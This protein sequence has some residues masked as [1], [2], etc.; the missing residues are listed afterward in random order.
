MIFCFRNNFDKVVLF[1]Y[2]APDLAI[3][4]FKIYVAYYFSVMVVCRTDNFRE[5]FRRENVL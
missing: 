3:N 2:F 4:V 5:R 1:S